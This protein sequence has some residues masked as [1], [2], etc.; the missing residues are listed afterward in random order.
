LTIRESGA[1]YTQGVIMDPAN[2]LTKLEAVKLHL[3][4]L[5]VR[6]ADLNEQFVHSGGKGGQNVNKVSTAVRLRYKD[7]DVKC[8]EERSQL[9]NRI[10]AREILVQRIEN[11]RERTRLTKRAEFEKAR[12]LKAGRPRAIKKQI[13]RD[14]RK[15]SETKKNR[16]YSPVRDE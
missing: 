12:K 15:N 13:L 14:K 10:R 4:R 6:E 16:K 2:S 11:K 9:L 8:M 3:L 1:Y 7:E 5:G